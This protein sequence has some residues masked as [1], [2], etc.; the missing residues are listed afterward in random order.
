MRV[1]SPE[2]LLKLQMHYGTEPIF[3]LEVAWSTSDA[4]KV[5]YSDQKINGSDYPSPAIISVSNFDTA[6]KLTGASD[7]QAIS[8]VL[9]DI[10]GGIKTIL[11]TQDIHKRPCWLYQTFKGL[12]DGQKFLIFKG[13]IS[14]PIIWDEGARTLSFDIATTNQDN[15]VAFSMEEGD[16]PNVPSDALGKVWPL[17]FGTVCN[18]EAVQVRSP[19]KGYL[20]AGEGVHDFTL[21][22][23]ICQARYISCPDVSDGETTVTVMGGG[24]TTVTRTQPDPTCI[25][26]RFDTICALLTQYDEQVTY[27]HPYFTVVG[28]DKFPQT[29]V[30]TL[31]IDGAKF[32]GYFTGNTFHVQS[33]WHP[34]FAK[35]ASADLDCHD[36]G[37]RGYS[38]QRT[39]WTAAWAFDTTSLTWKYPRT[40]DEETCDTVGGVNITDTGGPTAS[41]KAYDD[42]ATSNFCWLPA[43]TEV[44]LE[45]EAEILHIVSLI[46][47]TI[48]NVAA[49]KKQGENSNR[50]LLMTVPTSLYTVYE[51]DYDGYTVVEIGFAEKLSSI[52]ERW[53]DEIYVSFTSDIGPNPCDII[54]WLVTKYLPTISIDTISFSAVKTSLTNY[55]TNFYVKTKQSVFQTIQDIAY[56]S[57]CAVYIRGD[58]LYIKYLALEPTSVRTLTSDDIIVSSFKIQYTETENL[59]TKQ[60]IS[61]RQTDAPILKET[62]PDQKIVLK[63]NVSKYG[64]YAE[65]HNYYTQNTF[66]TILKS[67]TFWLIRTANT[68]KTVEFDTPLS[69]LDLD[70]FDCI[71]LN[72]SH[73]SATPVKVVITSAQYNNENNTIHFECLTPIRSGEI[74]P[75]PF[76]W[77]ASID[78]AMIFPLTAEEAHAGAGYAFTVTPPTGHI[79][80]GG[81]VI[82]QDERRVIMSSGDQFPSDYGDTYPVV[83]CQISDVMDVEESDP[84]FEAWK[85][86]TVADYKATDNQLNKNQATGGSQKDKKKEKPT[87]CGEPNY[88]MGCSYEVNVTYITPT[89]VTTGK[90]GGCDSGPCS[91][92]GLGQPCDGSMANFC[93]IFGAL[94]A[95]WAFYSSMKATIAGLHCGYTPGKSDPY[96]VSEPK[97]FADTSDPVSGKC[98]TN[99][100]GDPTK[101]LAGAGETYAAKQY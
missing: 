72:I 43:G 80:R 67:A 100:P 99:P 6:L 4:V 7:S 46:P 89:L 44:F 90:T 68:W 34:D 11:D 62:D 8:V 9:D 71:T 92:G 30:V 22:P 91:K 24:T 29:T 85:R 23:R 79:L 1:I 17:V 45:A 97:G 20:Y 42:M 58:T 86:A 52:N 15:E 10:D 18:M 95:A 25:A 48:N 12:A 87:A 65:D 37:D 56:Q 31:N 93:H 59:G 16:F 13:E 64:I 70:V 98:D 19:R 27:E 38:L 83:L 54:E 73:L 50:E 26:S 75:Y 78:P 94:F 53:S 55:P 76:F 66:D 33:R 21:E 40:A 61:W 69:M 5:A 63:H 39:A 49:Y 28:G 96:T 36:P 82:L 101:K 41:Q 74:T 51:T 35:T 57:R 3:I 32:R 77:P 88:K 2:A 84:V 81:D 47:G 14:S 60:I